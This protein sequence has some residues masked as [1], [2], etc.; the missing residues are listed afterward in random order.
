MEKQ[1]EM[2]TKIVSFCVWVVELRLFTLSQSKLL[3]LFTL[4]D[5]LLDL[6]SYGCIDRDLTKCKFKPVGTEKQ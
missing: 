1:E 3:I 6:A 5:K 4:P 2:K